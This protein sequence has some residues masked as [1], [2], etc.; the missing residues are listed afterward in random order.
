M[1]LPKTLQFQFLSSYLDTLR[2]QMVFSIKIFVIWCLIGCKIAIFGTIFRF[3][4]WFG[5]SNANCHFT[6]EI[7]M[8][9]PTNLY[10]KVRKCPKIV[11]FLW[12][13]MEKLKKIYLIYKFIIGCP[14][15]S[16]HPVG[17][18]FSLIR[19]ELES[20]LQPVATRNACH[21]LNENFYR[22]TRGSWLSWLRLGWVRLRIGSLRVWPTAGT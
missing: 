12:K 1:I 17:W 6:T 19:L 8:F 14:I 5:D 3:R 20:G 10:M 7:C 13:R 4:N 15:L 21:S 2:G 11:F 9:V 18:V 22:P 16:S